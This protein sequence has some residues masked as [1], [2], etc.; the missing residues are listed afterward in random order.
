MAMV[1]YHPPTKKLEALEILLELNVGKAIRFQ[2][3]GYHFLTFLVRSQEGN[4]NFLAFLNDE[5]FLNLQ[6]FL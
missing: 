5:L 1:L 6:C 2:E 3:L 4:L